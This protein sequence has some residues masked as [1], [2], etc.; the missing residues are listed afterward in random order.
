MTVRA[1]VGNI[2]GMDTPEL[3]R[4]LQNLIRIGTVHSVDHGARCVRVQ[5][6][7]L[8]TTWL[9]WL[10]RRAGDTRTWNPPTVGEQ[11]V[12]LSPSGN[13]AAGIVLPGLPSNL[14]DTPSHSQDDHVIRFS[15]GAT[16]S[17]NHATGHL[18]VSGIKTATI[19]ASDSITLDTPH[20]HCTGQLTADGL[21]TYKDGIAGTEGNN[22]NSVTGSFHVT[23]G[24]VVA[25]NIS[26]KGHVHGGVL[27]GGSDTGGPK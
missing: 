2:G 18:A 27:S 16:F 19:S 4:L 5:S 12:V 3:S 26:L 10:E 9:P 22:G 1:R 8:V 24:D 20:T 17:Y 15:D 21:L 25:D 23:S 13:T 7:E 6:G 11:V 14:K